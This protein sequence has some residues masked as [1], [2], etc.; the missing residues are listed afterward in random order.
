MS[1]RTDPLVAGHLRGTIYTFAEVGDVIPMHKH[2]DAD[3]H[4]V[5]VARGRVRLHGPEIG[6]IEYGEGAVIDIT[7]GV[8]HEV[9]S[10]TQNART[11]HII[12]GA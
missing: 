9:V 8:D 7:A 6:D 10:L 1:L 4:I 12:T 11:V 5:I 3:T 2:T